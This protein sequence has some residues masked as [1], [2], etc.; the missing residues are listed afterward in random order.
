MKMMNADNVSLTLHDHNVVT[1]TEVDGCYLHNAAFVEQHMI[2]Y[3][4]IYFW[5]CVVAVHLVPCTLLV[6][7]NA[8]LVKTMSVMRRRRRRLLTRRG[9]GSGFL[10][11]QY[12]RLGDSIATTYM[13]VAIVGVLLLVELP[14]AVFL[15]LLIIENTWTHP[16]MPDGV[17]SSAALFINLL[18]VSCYPVNL[19]IYCAMSRQFR[20]TFAAIFTSPEQTPAGGQIN[21]PTRTH[22]WAAG[23]DRP[24]SIDEV[25]GGIEVE[26]SPAEETPRQLALFSCLGRSAAVTVTSTRI[27]LRLQRNAD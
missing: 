19:F 14:L 21:R 12:R 23:L 5:L 8:T 11:R 22:N 9:G 27:D 16:V 13:L 7:L 26:A 25:E 3:F 15:I 18:I 2:L 17:A 6:V 24:P 20:T 1:D 10:D 4:G